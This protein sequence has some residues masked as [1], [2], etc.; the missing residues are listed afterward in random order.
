MSAVALGAGLVGLNFVAPSVSRSAARL[1]GGYRRVGLEV[2]RRSW[3][4]LRDSLGKEPG[5]DDDDDDDDDG[6][7]VDGDGAIRLLET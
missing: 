1:G 2:A 7:D 4:N 6:G 5:D 3:E